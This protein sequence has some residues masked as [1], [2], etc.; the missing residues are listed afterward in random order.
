MLRDSLPAGASIIF[1]NPETGKFIQFALRGRENLIC[2]VPTAILTVEEEKLRE[3]M[4]KP[5]GIWRPVNSSPIN[6]DS[7]P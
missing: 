2:N 6:A 7:T 1:E 3:L 5:Q 4:P